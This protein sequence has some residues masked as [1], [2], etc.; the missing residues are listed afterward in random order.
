MSV[1]P[2]DA[3]SKVTYCHIFIFANIDLCV[4]VSTGAG[5]GLTFLS[6]IVNLVYAII[7]LGARFYT[8]F[9]HNI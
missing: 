5:V 6:L 3:T 4:S 2:S 7:E 8:Q 9:H 1:A